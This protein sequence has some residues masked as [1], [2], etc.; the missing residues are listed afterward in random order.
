MKQTLSDIRKGFWARMTPE[1]RRAFVERREQ[2]R[3]RSPYAHLR[4]GQF[5]KP[6]EVAK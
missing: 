6:R 4:P 3:Q 5:G 1:Q 2:A